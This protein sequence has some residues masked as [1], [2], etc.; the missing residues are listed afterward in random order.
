M[1]FKRPVPL[2][3]VQIADFTEA[4][5]SPSFDTMLVQETE[6]SI[7]HGADSGSSVHNNMTGVLWNRLG[8]TAPSR[9]YHKLFKSDQSN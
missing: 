9:S 2:H 6:T 8:D 7:P 3:P 5:E 1:Y 4:N